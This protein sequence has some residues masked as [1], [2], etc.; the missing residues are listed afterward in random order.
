MYLLSRHRYDE[1]TTESLIQEGT[2][3]RSCL[4]QREVDT[5]APASIC[6]A[7]Y[8]YRLPLDTGAGKSTSPTSHLAPCRPSLPNAVGMVRPRH[9]TTQSDQFPNYK[10]LGPGESQVPPFLQGYPRSRP[11][12]MPAPSCS[13]PQRVIS[14]ETEW[15]PLTMERK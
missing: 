15:Y 14:R 3:R 12:L 8:P 10:C 9:N 5:R 2:T 4:G 1:A 13:R 6:L 11:V 7:L